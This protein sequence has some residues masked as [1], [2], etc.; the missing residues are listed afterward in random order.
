MRT[1]GGRS[2]ISRMKYRYPLECRPSQSDNLIRYESSF[3]TVNGA[4]AIRSPAGD[5]ATAERLAARAGRQ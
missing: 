1:S 3:A 4:S 2:S 5:G